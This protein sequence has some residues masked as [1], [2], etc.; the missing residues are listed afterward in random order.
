MAKPTLKVVTP[1]GT[2]TRQTSRPYQF[3]VVARGRRHDLVTHLHQTSVEYKEDGLRYNRAKL[4]GT[5]PI[6][7]W[8]SR[9]Q[10]EREVAAAEA[11]LA[12]AADHLAA[13]LAAADA[14]LVAPFEGACGTWSS[15]LH[16][17][18]GEARRLAE[19]YR[20]VRIFSLDG[21]EVR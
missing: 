16:N 9:E 17:A 11:W 5:E 15:R 8:Q 7:E 10:I 4:A 2:V 20:D 18:R 21:Q 19:H 13:D 3:V 12:H 1:H 6:R 14:D